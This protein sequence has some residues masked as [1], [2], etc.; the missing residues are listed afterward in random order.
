MSSLVIMYV[1]KELILDVCKLDVWLKYILFNGMS[2]QSPWTDTILF[3]SNVYQ[4]WKDTLNSQQTWDIVVE[5]SWNFSRRSEAVLGCCRTVLIETSF[6]DSIS[7]TAQ[8]KYPGVWLYTQTFDFYG[9][10][11]SFVMELIARG[12]W[13]ASKVAK[14]F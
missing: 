8:T 5:Q 12:I 4:F 9:A 2:L 11:F 1:C 7:L 6:I 13:L 10:N 3:A 14:H